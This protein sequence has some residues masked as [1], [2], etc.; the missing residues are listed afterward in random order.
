MQ[1]DIDDTEGM[2]LATLITLAATVV[3]VAILMWLA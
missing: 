3:A 1:N 2:G